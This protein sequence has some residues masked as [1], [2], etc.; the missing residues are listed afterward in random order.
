MERPALSFITFALR[1]STGLLPPLCSRTL[2]SRWYCASVPRPIVAEA[3]DA[4]T[5]LELHVNRWPHTL[6]VSYLWLRDHCRCP[7]CYNYITNQRKLDMQ[8][9]PLNIRPASVKA[10]REALEIQWPD[11]HKSKYEYK[12]LWQNTYEGRQ[13]SRKR[14]QRLWNANTFPKE[15]LTTVPLMDI[16]N[17]DKNGLKCLISSIVTHGFGCISGVPQDVD[18]TREVVEE[19]CPVKPTLFGSMWSFQADYEHA[20]TAYSDEYLGAHTDT[21]YLSEA[22]RIQVFHCLEQAAEGG[23]T[24]LV[25]GFNVAQQFHDR[26]PEGYA[27]LS[28]AAI[29]SEYIGD[30]QH[31]FCLDT[32][33]K[34]NPATGDLI[35]FRYNI[36]DRAPLA[37]IPVGKMQEFYL[38]MRNLGKIVQNSRNEHWLKLQPGTLLLIDNWRVMHGRNKYSGPRVMGGCYLDNDGFTSKARTLEVALD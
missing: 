7:E 21:T 12:F 13:T 29:P 22:C 30:G 36:Y 1:R 31:M 33:L 15:N 25:D 2:N 28:K 16:K 11:G 32:V 34:H 37:S 24:I 8:K 3:I 27:F 19:I 4:V 17:P 35:Q 20:D 23:E 38:H 10:T 6:G 18:G 5:R 14:S 9:I 26:H